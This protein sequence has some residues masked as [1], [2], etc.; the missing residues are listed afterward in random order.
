MDVYEQWSERG[1]TVSNDAQAIKA[2]LSGY[3]VE[4]QIAVEPTNS[5]HR[6]V[7]E[8]AHAGGHEVYMVDPYRLNHYREGVGQRAKVGRADARLLARYLSNE[9]GQV[10]RWSPLGAKEKRV[11]QLLK[12]RATLVGA[13]TQLRQSLSDVDG[14]HEEIGALL[15]QFERA[16]RCL[17]RAM[18]REVK[19][20]GWLRW[21]VRCQAI[22][23]VGP[24]TAVAM[25]ATFH[26][27]EFQSVDAFIAFMGLDVRVK[28]SGKFKG[29]RKLTK[30]GDSELRR[31]LYNA[32]MAACS[33]PLWAPYYLSLRKRGLSATAALMALGRKLARVCFVLMKQDVK[34]D[35]AFC[36]G[37]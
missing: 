20:L 23:G 25:V 15:K 8:Q 28:D 17:G 27:G 11:W 21:V 22:P 18:R 37:G 35:P 12:R 10:R 9:G 5:Y 19:A 14:E 1:Y 7:S 16:I 34:F 6:E 31:L 2:W 13:R 26:R 24:L 3:E 4:L 29:R 30:K 33:N 36:P 32:A